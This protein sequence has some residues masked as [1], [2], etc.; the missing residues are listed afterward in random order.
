MPEERQT[1]ADTMC[2][3]YRRYYST[4][5]CSRAHA[6]F[7]QRLYGRDFCQQGFADM[8]QVERLLGVLHL[9]PES[10]VL[11]LGCGSGGIA[12][13]ISDLTGAVVTGLDNVPEAI[14]LAEKRALRKAGRLRFVL[15][16]MDRMGFPEA[17]FDAIVAIDAL[18]FTDLNQT[19]AQMRFVL[20]PGGEVGIL[21]SH[22]ANPKV[23]LAMFPRETLPPDRTPLAQ[24]LQQQGFAYRTWDLTKEDYQHARRKK[25]IAENLRA[26]FEAEG[27]LFLYENRYGEAE[28]VMAAIK[29]RAHRR[30]LYHCCRK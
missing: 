16:S 23:P 14:A 15:G 6:L 7:C 9:Q 19:I 18:Y 8:R 28:G 12:E 2:E 22:G 30:Y 27:N 3:W 13:Y 24:A 5:P 4:A 10:R 11:E 1:S 20:A 29:A 21:Y 17:T 26:R 25:D